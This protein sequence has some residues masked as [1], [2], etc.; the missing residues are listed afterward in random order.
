MLLLDTHVVLW[1]ALEPSRLSKRARAAI[2]TA[3]QSSQGLAICDIT[4][5]EITTLHR[6]G[7]IQLNAGLQAFL[8]EIETRFTV[9]PISS[10]ACVAA[11]SLPG[12]Y[13]SDPADRIIGATA[14]AE[15]LTLL[16]AD[17]AIRRSKVLTTLW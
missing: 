16:S 14:L 10:R 1:L 9:L 15:G 4:L 17:D 2:E 11:V 6:K 5:L 12:N 3:R 8:C 13:P 7:R